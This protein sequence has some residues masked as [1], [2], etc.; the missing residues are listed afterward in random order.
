MNRLDSSILWGGAVAANQIEGAYDEGNKGISIADI[1]PKPDTIDTARFY[2]MGYTK[3]EIR[4]LIEDKISFFPR[5][6]AIDFYHRYED[7]IKLLK[8]LGF[9]C[10]RFSIA[11]SR[12]YPGGDDRQPNDS[13]LEYYDKLIDA[14]IAAGME[15][16]VTLSHYE[17]PVNLVLNYKG[18][19]D[20]KLIGF[21]VAYAK[22]ILE[23]YNGKV[24]YWIPFN[25]IN[26][27]EIFEENGISHGDF[28]SLGL[29]NGEH[30]N[31]QQARY[32]AIHHQF[33]ASAKVAEYAH[34]LNPKN[35]IGVMNASD[36]QYPYCCKPENIFE[37]ARLNRIRNYFFFDV[38][39]RGAYPGYMKRYFTETSIDIQITEEDEKLL[40]DNTADFMAVS[41]YFSMAYT[42]DGERIQNPYL[43][44]TP[45]NWAIDPL[46]LRHVL[47]EYWQVY[48][49][50]IMIAENGYGN[51][52]TF[53]NGQIHDTER[54][55]Y[56]EAHMDAVNEAAKD[57]VSIFA[58]TSWAPIDLISDSTGEM[59]K[60]YGYIYVD[61]D[62]NGNGT[63]KRYK[64]DSFFWFKGLMEGN[65]KV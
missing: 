16:I 28:A 49:K 31:W 52:D 50:P 5:R 33:L 13:G 47:N 17:M 40:K 60:R 8:E 35:K 37:T 54:I 14:V 25:Q 32:Q 21:F 56:L 1:K 64:K 6:H 7:D 3:E 59:E 53:E 41:Y 51:Y 9:T 15:P 29:V 20:R 65:Y 27:I 63:G 19:T 11:W 44:T 36:L 42:E 46:G 26:M 58:Y 61:Y 24:F 2:G 55:K 34:R 12:I 45:W 39:L 18:W 57:G 22:T 10:F 43:I 23:R 62:N 48:Q 30:E 4:Q 38:L